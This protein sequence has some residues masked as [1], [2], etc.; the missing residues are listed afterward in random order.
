[1]NSDPETPDAP[2]A[3]APR[4]FPLVVLQGVA[5]ALALAAQF[6]V[7]VAPIFS[8]AGFAVAAVLFIVAERLR[9]AAPEPEAA[10]LVRTPPLVWGLLAGGVLVCAAAGLSVRGHGDPAFNHILW[11][12]GL[13]FLA[14]AALAAWR[15]G[16]LRPERG[17]AAAFAIVAVVAGLLFFWDLTTVPPEVHGDD[18]EVG[19][20]AVRLL[21]ESF[22][23]FTTGWFE[24]PMFHAFPTAV[25]LEVAG[26]N[27][28][29]L[30]GTSAVLGLLSV[31]M[32]FAVA[33][34]LWGLEVALLSS[35]VLASSRFFIHLSRTGYHYIDTPFVSIL[36]VFLFLRLWYDFRLGAAVWCGILLGVGIQTYYAT[37]LAPL[38]LAATFLLWLFGTPW[39]RVWARTA[40][41][42]VLVIA[43]LATAAPMIGY[44]SNH[45][46]AFMARTRGTS[47]FNPQSI[48]HLSFGYKT[49]DFGEILAIQFKKALTLFNLSGD[50]SVQYSYRGGGLLEPVS[51]AF[52]IL[53]LAVLIARPLRRRNNLV[54]LWLVVPT[55][56]GAALTIDTPFY[57]RISGIMPFVALTVAVGLHSFLESIREAVPARGGRVAAG[58]V[59]A[60]VL[61]FAFSNNLWTYFVEYAPNHR[62]SP[63]VEI[64]SFVREYGGG[65][66][67]YM[68]GG[69]PGFYIKHG[70]VRFLTH[71]YDTRDIIDLERHAL[72]QPLDPARSVFVV[73][74]KG[75]HLIPRLEALVGPI[76]SRP[77]HNIHGVLQFIG[78]VPQATAPPED[79]SPPPPVAAPAPAASEP[80]PFL[81]LLGMVRA[82]GLSFVAR[83]QGSAL[84]RYALLALLLGVA[85]L[86]PLLIA[87]RGNGGGAA[88]ETG[89]SPGFALR[90]SLWLERLL[91]FLFGP[92]PRDTGRSPPRWLVVVLLL[93]VVGLGSWLRLTRLADLPAGLFCDEAG[94][95][96]N[97]YSLWETAKDETGKT[98]P[99]YVWSFGVS[100]KNPVFI[101]SGILPVALGGLNDFTVRVTSAVYGIATVV[102]IFF[103]G[104]ALLGAWA[105]LLAAAILAVLPW[106]LHFSRIAFE[107]ITYPFFFIVGLTM[108]V[109]WT[110]GRR[111][112]PAAMLFFGVSLYTYVP[113]KLFVPLFV[114]IFCVLYLPELW[115]RR[116]EAALAFAV[117]AITVA[118]VIV[119]D[120]T[121]Q[122]Q[123]S[124]YFRNTSILGSDAPPE[125]LARRFVEN[126]QAFFSYRFLFQSGD[127]ISRHSVPGHGELYPF[128]LPLLV[129]GLVFCVGRRGRIFL[130]PL[131]WLALYPIAG[132]LMTEIPTASRAFIGAPGFALLAA[133]GAAAVLRLPAQILPWRTAAVAAQA[134]LVAAG[135]WWALP[136][137]QRYWRL[138]TEDYPLVSAKSY[139]GFQFG[140]RDVVR[141]FLEHQDEYDQFFLSPH[142]NN[143]PQSFLLFYSAY[144][145]E[146]LHQGGLGAMQ[147]DLRMRVSSPEDLGAY[148]YGRRRLWAVTPEE[149]RLFA[150]YEE[151]ERIIA[152]DGTAAF[153]L[154]DV[155][156]PKS[157]VHQWRIAGPY[158]IGASP[159]LPSPEDAAPHR[160]DY[161]GRPWRS[162]GL[163]QAAVR[164]NDYFHRNADNACAWAVAWVDTD[165][166]RPVGVFTGFD[167]KGEV[168][169]NGERVLLHPRGSRHDT[170]VDTEVGESHLRAGRN[171]VAVKSCEIRDDWKF[172]FRL[173]TPDG[174]EIEALRWSVS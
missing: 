141:Y 24:L 9:P 173:G 110:Q 147:R 139:T 47:V 15:G 41:F 123:S 148:G 85:V 37:R 65:K 111:T 2:P 50:S 98:L 59:A 79:G 96:Y 58:V 77:Y 54:L 73:M 87:R 159:P 164:L 5:V 108:L 48:K 89:A 118:P 6:A 92:S 78:V 170:I 97:S 3:A 40:R 102:A 100:F 57:P 150:D 171:F 142:Q 127:S 132:A 158:E 93:G 160:G 95:G 113:A 56:A 35:L 137:V 29:G 62:H 121:H 74:A 76:D 112:L 161:A 120:L 99:L 165:L 31:M 168:W 156:R 14:A 30:R 90:P 140:H 12:I 105:G 33:R 13:V 10:A 53:G 162:Y 154:V 27:L 52:F 119:F 51:A 151:K 157:F 46:D 166:E 103:L 49:D 7:S 55:I 115:R 66:T 146:K 43:A 126:Y 39:S 135:A 114:A 61:L 84:F 75:E 138:Y 145:P 169:I 153:V 117:L 134:L 163:P 167:D 16:A 8:L 60:V 133:I 129:V 86:V 44:F 152:P 18:A 70:T 20:D 149:L 128:L 101:Y 42:A 82:L 1:M 116:R 21:E 136:E 131:V 172:Y 144:T 25:G 32:L 36:A 67:S 104:R 106:H 28:A 17:A 107:L 26:V 22:N 174:A 4:R 155:R 83:L 122:R 72:E 63:A 19:N 68:V 38:L 71:G 94:L 109:R 143:Q 91:A 34:R 81:R 88:A 130:M 80:G 23:L 11:A 124:Q 45:W 64:A 69:A 125:E